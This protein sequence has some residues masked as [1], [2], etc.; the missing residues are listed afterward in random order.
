MK[1]SIQQETDAILAQHDLKKTE[2]RVKLL[3]FFLK[4]KVAFSQADLIRFLEKDLKT[5]DRVSVYR[6][7]TQMKE[8]GLIHEVDAN[9]YVSCTHQCQEHGHLLLYCQSCDKH[10]EVKDHRIL[11]S[12]YKSLQQFHFLSSDKAVFLR[13][14]CETCAQ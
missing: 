2:L 11:D 7:L 8:L 6:N 5:V 13:G 14:V 12:F 9:K 4:S 10:E 1:R 3:E